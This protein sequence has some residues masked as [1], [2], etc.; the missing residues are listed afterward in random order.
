MLTEYIRKALEKARYEIIEDQDPYYG[1][2]P[3]LDGIWA[4][5]STLEECRRELEKTIED[6]LLFSVAKGLPIPPLEDVEIH[7]PERASSP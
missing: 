7:V 2:V 4:S 6:W 1:E 5:G 3:G